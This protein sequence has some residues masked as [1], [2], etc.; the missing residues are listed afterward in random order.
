MFREGV[1]DR[2]KKSWLK[3]GGD[4]VRLEDAIRKRCRSLWRP[5][6]EPASPPGYLVQSCP[7]D[8]VSCDDVYE[9]EGEDGKEEESTCGVELPGARVSQD[10][11]TATRTAVCR[12]AAPETST[13]V[14]IP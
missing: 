11:G 4:G 6:L 9:E 1:G 12:N 5:V 13:C 14:K 7:G 3:T 8:A 10:P 2:G